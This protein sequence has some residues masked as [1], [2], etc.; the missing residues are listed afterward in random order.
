MADIEVHCGSCGSAFLVS[1]SMAGLVATCPTCERQISVPIPEGARGVERPKLQIKR[2][3]TLTGG[4]RC[5]N[6]DGTIPD[7]AVICV[8]CGYDMRTGRTVSSRGMGAQAAKPLFA[9]LGVVILGGI[10]WTVLRLRSDSGV[11][12]DAPPAVP[13]AQPAAPAA[14]QEPAGTTAVAEATASIES[15]VP[16]VSAVAETNEVEQGPSLAEIQEKLTQALNARYPM[17]TP[18]SAVV[19]RRV[20]GLVHRGTL[21]ALGPESVTVHT[22]EGDVEVAYDV[23]DRQTRMLCDAAFRQKYVEHRSKQAVPSAETF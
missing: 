11:I 10:V 13:V 6:C 21:V 20:N 5:P 15:V 14:V 3:T 19:L 4:K 7:G 17:F 2:E 16:A 9:L 12:G 22:E 1:E 18:G 8:Q 23:L